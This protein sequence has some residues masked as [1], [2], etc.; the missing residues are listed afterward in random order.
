MWVFRFKIA[1]CVF[2]IK[3][4]GNWGIKELRCGF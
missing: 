4:L 2:G 3:E 1:D